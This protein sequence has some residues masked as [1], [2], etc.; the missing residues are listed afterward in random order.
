[1][2]EQNQKK[3]SSYLNAFL[4]VLLSF[5]TNTRILGGLAF[6]YWAFNN[7]EMMK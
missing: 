6:V 2:E 4:T 5:G 7:P 1:M 3:T